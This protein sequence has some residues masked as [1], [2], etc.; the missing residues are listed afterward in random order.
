M[1]WSSCNTKLI[2]QCLIRKSN[3]Y[4]YSHYLIN[5]INAWN[6]FTD[7]DKIFLSYLG[8]SFYKNLQDTESPKSMTE[9]KSFVQ[10]TNV[11]LPEEDCK[12]SLVISGL[13]WW[14]KKSWFSSLLVTYHQPSLAVYELNHWMERSKSLKGNN[15]RQNCSNL[16]GE[17]VSKLYLVKLNIFLIKCHLLRFTN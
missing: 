17:N 8:V 7:L 13:T 3:I 11:G 4:N 15:S 6:F 5:A 1:Y 16:C 10:K 2:Y 9:Y 12:Q 14:N